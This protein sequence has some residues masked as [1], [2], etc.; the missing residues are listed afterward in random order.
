MN[1]RLGSESGVTLIELMLVVTII[2]IVMAV[3]T[4]NFLA[5]LPAYRLRGAVNKVAASVQLIKMRAIATNRNTWLVVY[6]SNSFFT[7][8]VDEDADSAID[9]PGEYTS[10]GM[11][12][13]DSFGGAP[14]FFLPQDVSFGM[15]S[16]CVSG[17]DGV[18]GAAD[19]MYIAGIPA[20]DNDIGFRPTG[21]P[22]VNRGIPNIISPTDSVVIY[23]E[24]TRDQGFAISI[25]ITGRV[26]T[27]QCSGGSWQ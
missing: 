1:G 14:G 20:A 9:S 21:L 17:P 25:G 10:A 18:A 6:P 3:G 8:F 22:I 11:D 7:G 16:S 15:P 4:Y 2:S 24:N 12:M 19:G 27:Y 5:E 13:P 26:K 23:L